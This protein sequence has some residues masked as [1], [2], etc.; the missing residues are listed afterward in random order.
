[1]ERTASPDRCSLVTVIRWKVFINF[2]LRKLLSVDAAVT[3]IVIIIL[4]RIESSGY[5]YVSTQHKIAVLKIID[6]K[7][8]KQPTNVSSVFATLYLLGWK[9]QKNLFLSSFDIYL[10]CIAVNHFVNH[11]LTAIGT[12]YLI[13]SCVVIA[14]SLLN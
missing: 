13:L 8:N 7:N 4:S 5:T 10:A 14:R 12:S 2:S 1:M 3:E 11:F 6:M 9:W